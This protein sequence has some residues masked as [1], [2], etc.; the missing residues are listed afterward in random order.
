M[1]PFAP[2]I[3]IL[4]GLDKSG[5]S[6]MTSDLLSFFYRAVTFKLF[7]KPTSLAPEELVK[8]KT[9]YSELFAQ[10]KRLNNKHTVIFDRAYP[11][12]LVYSI[13]RGYDAF[14]DPDWWA[15][16]ERL[17]RLPN[18]F[19]IYCSA[20]DDVVAKRLITE[21]EEY[22]TAEE[23]PVLRSRYEQFVER[24]KIPVLGVDST[25]PRDKNLAS[26]IKEL[27]TRFIHERE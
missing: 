15:L 13:K 14:D 22:M 12:E 17:S 2:M 23:I 20:P 24:T 10:A 25:Q 9:A 8:I 7:N 3:L 1:L 21:K 18:L 16:D 27:E 6:S 4:E 5:K 26:I 19:I 11:S